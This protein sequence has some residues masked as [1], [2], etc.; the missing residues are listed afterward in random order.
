MGMYGLSILCAAAWLSFESLADT[1]E[2]NLRRAQG[3][4]RRRTST[5]S[6]RCTPPPPPRTLLSCYTTPRRRLLLKVR[7]HTLQPSFSLPLTPILLPLV[8]PPRKQYNIC[9]LQFL[10]SC[11][12]QTGEENLASQLVVND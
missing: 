9:L 7:T 4:R 3:T 6:S 11:L 8:G 1:G 10:V 5:T 12:D 2:I